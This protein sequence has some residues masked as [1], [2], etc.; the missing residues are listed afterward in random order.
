MSRPNARY[1][2]VFAVVRVDTFHHPSA[3]T[4][5]MITV[6]EVLWDKE[7]AEQEVERLNRLNADKGAVYFWKIT[8]LERISPKREE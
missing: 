3:P 8:R 1:D 2:H 4:K 7:A 5:D 6:K